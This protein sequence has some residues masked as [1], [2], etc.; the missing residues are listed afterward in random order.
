M[1]VAKK[2][3]IEPKKLTHTIYCGDARDIES[4]V[5]K[6]SVHL[7]VTSPP[8]PMIAMWDD[9]FRKLDTAIPL[10]DEWNRSNVWT[11]FESMH[12]QL[13]TV[14]GKLFQSV[15][16]GG[17]VAINIGDATRTVAGEFTL[18]PN[19]ARITTSM[20]K[21]GFTPLPNIYWK[22]PTNGPNAFLGSGFKPVNA[23]VTLDCEHILLF[24]K[25]KKRVFSADEKVYREKSCFTKEERDVWFSQTWTGI[26][27]VRQKEVNGRRSAAFPEAI[28]ERLIRMFSIEGDTVLDPYVGTGTTSTVA[29]RLNRS[30]IGFDIDEEFVKIADEGKQ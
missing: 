2:A 30:A 11:V 20:V 9:I 21:S 5:Q 14:W 22:K 1:S 7:V 23:Y 10:F 12:A 24:R 3:K 17:I 27:G 13:D 29:F 25:G 16:E 19:G 26:K 8:Y 6:N 4:V 15:V 18:F 28:A